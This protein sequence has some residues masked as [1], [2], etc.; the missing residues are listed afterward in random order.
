MDTKE[1]RFLQAALAENGQ[2]IAAGYVPP[3]D[4]TPS[5]ADERF[6]A[7]ARAEDGL[8]VSAGWTNDGQNGRRAFPNVPINEA[9][10]P[11]FGKEKGKP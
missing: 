1:E 8:P 5:G 10:A 4:D 6:L 11:E 7:A 9:V 3:G 2:P